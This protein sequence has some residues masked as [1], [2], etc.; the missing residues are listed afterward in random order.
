MNVAFNIF[1]Y[2]VWFLATYYIVLLILIV[3]SKKDDLFEKKR[4]DFKKPPFVSVIVPA[5][6]EEGKIKHTIASLKKIKYSKLEFLIMNDGSKDGT[7][8]EVRESI[9]GDNRFRFID[10]K[11]NK[12][13][14]AT[15]NDGFDVAK[16]EFVATMD[17]DSMIEPNI[18]RKVLPYFKDEKMAAVTVS[19]LVKNPKS[20]FHK[21]FEL[22]YIIGLSLFLKIFSTFNAVFVTPGPFSIYRKSFIKEIGGFDVHNITEDLEIAYRIQKKRY[23]IANCMDAKVYTIL[24]PTFK[25]IVVQRKRWYSGAIQTLSKHRDMLLNNKYGLF[26]HFVAYNYTLIF[27]GVCLFLFTLYMGFSNVYENVMYFRHTNFNFLEHMKNFEFDFLAF[28]RVSF[29]GAMSISFT[30]LMLFLGLSLTKNKKSERKLGILGYPLLFFLYQLFWIVSIIAVL[31][32][33]KI[34]WR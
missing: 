33:K 29:L 24:P 10:R 26:G 1:L 18:F 31:R 23:K 27:L 28:G 14:A 34:K 16:G 15:L 17:A 11:L 12:G 7:S 25:Q 32:G 9:K 19:V 3:L 5:Y 22:E 20:F 21:V 6:N 2:A 4:F 13:K 30:M 8:N